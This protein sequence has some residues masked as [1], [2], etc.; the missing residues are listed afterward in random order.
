MKNSFNI[1][2]LITIVTN[3]S[4][5]QNPFYA[6]YDWKDHVTVE[7]TEEEKNKDVIILFE[8]RSVNIYE[9]GESVV[10]ANL[11]HTK[12][13]LNTDA[14]ITQSNK[15]YV[16]G[17]NSE[18][19]VIQ[20]AR[21]IN[22]NGK[23]IY[24]NKEDVKEFKDEEGNTEYFYFALEGLEV[25][26]IVEYIQLYTEIPVF[27]GSSLY[28]QNS[29][30][31]KR[32]EF[33]IILPSH[34][35]FEIVELNG[36][37][38][39]AI[40]TM[41]DSLKRY[42]LDVDNVVGVEEEAESPYN[43][44]LQKCYYKLHKNLVSGKSNFYNYTDV[45]KIVY[46]N[47][48]GEVSKSALKQLKSIVKEAENE[49]SDLESKLRKLEYL[50]FS[51]YAM[52]DYN[53]DEYMNLDFIFKNKLT[54]EAGMTHLYI[55]LL[56]LMEVSHELVLTS[57]R[58]ESNFDQ[59]FEGYNLLNDYLVYINDLDMYF[60]PDLFS[61]LGFPNSNLTGAK[62]L[63]IKE[64]KLEDIYVAI[65]KVKPI[66][67]VPSENSVDVINTRVTFDETLLEP[68]IYL[69]RK[70]SGYKAMFPQFVI[71]FMD[72]ENVKNA[73]ENFMK[74]L[75]E[76]CTLSDLEFENDNSE[77]AGK[78]PFIGR[79]TVTDG[80]FLEKAGDK[81]LFKAGKL[82]GPQVEM[83]NKKE[84]KLPVSCAF[85]RRYQRQIIIEIPNGYQIKN[86]QDATMNVVAMDQNAAGF[87]SEYK[88]E[89]NKMT[90]DILEYYNVIDFSVEDYK[91]YERVINAAADFNKLVLV[92][93]KKP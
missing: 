69:E 62:G 23:I 78:Q 26:S 8:K 28:L 41:L 76:N 54:S 15:V 42:F 40:D 81:V 6:N 63:F 82:I 25:G 92:L 72:D 44:S 52:V 7:L 33:D 10:Q 48:Y 46:D 36:M 65:S 57:D 58:M 3:F 11:L 22:P 93:E 32:V 88:I 29:L 64:R 73:K 9:A 67:I 18:D 55:Q 66:K 13:L 34:L 60:S 70:A 56:K 2:L 77:V 38:E 17:G 51:D 59:G 37:P 21:V 30:D 24:L 39:F 12:K 68:T 43:A 14:G 35:E 5:S 27:S 75:D 4:L 71:S 47:F 50:I 53:Y 45:S 80:N 74:Y 1:I 61:R 90:I 84:R 91:S 83:Y 20:K 49:T 31:K 86:P 87:K 16:S 79:A 89:N 85:A 19:L